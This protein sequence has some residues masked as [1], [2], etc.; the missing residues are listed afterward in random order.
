M[1][2]FL[3]SDVQMWDLVTIAVIIFIAWAGHR[4]FKSEEDTPRDLSKT[5][6]YLERNQF[7]LMNRL[8]KLEQ[9]GWEWQAHRLVSR[10]AGWL[11]DMWYRKTYR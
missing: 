7:E 8:A 2:Q 3:N 11:E 10:L 1:Y 6:A 5:I 4:L 9:R